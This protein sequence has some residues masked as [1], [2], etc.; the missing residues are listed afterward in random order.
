MPEIEVR[1]KHWKMAD[2]LGE[3]RQ[4]LDHHNCVPVNFNISRSAT[5]SLLLW[6]AFKHEHEAELF[7]RAFRR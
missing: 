7:P 4:W 2:A 6:I 3:L 1:L 5:G